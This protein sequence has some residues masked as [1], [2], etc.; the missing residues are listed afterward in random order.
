[1]RLALEHFNSLISLANHFNNDKRCRDFIT[2]QRWG[3]AVVC[4]FCGCTHIYE[5]GNGDNQFKCAHCHKRFSCLVGTIFENTKLPLQKWFMAMYLISSHKKGISSRQLSRDID[6]TQK[7]AWFILHKIRTLFSQEDVVLSGVVECDEMYLGGRETNKHDS[8]K[9]EKTQGRSTKT[10]TPI[11]GMTMV[12]KT[13]DVDK[14]TGEVR[15]KTHTYEVAKKVFDTKAATLIPII[16]HFVAEGSTI[17][18]DELSAYNGLDK[19]YNHIFVRH[20]EREFTVGSYST[21][22]IEG[23]WGHFKRVIFGTYHFVSKAYL[24]RYIDEAVFRFNT[25]EMK[26]ADRFSIMFEKSI[27]KCDYKAVKMSA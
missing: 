8:K 16:E 17:V 10:K 2:E 18:T 20:G 13:E 4:P 6:V 3:K 11:F 19:K 9:T 5:C 25:K 27:G 26:E 22:G 21:N 15:E 14:E 12:W 1:M 7:T 24:E 23:F